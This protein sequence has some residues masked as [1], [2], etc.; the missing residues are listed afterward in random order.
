[1]TE[2]R[3]NLDRF[4]T[5]LKGIEEMVKGSR[6]AN[7]FVPEKLRGI[8]REVYEAVSAARRKTLEAMEDD[9]NTALALG[10]LHELAR[11]LNRALADKGFRKDPAAGD[12][13][14]E[15]RDCLLESGRVLG[16]FREAPGEYFAGQQKRFLAAKGLPEQEVLNLVVEREEARRSK[17]WKRADELR[18]KATA[19]GIVLEDG[20]QGTTWRPA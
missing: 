16:L 7:L 1:M 8:T 3:A 11:L 14:K 20:P 9:F 18:G 10:Y 13:L 17:D 6:E 15:G 12:L 5:A 2:A 4:Y 19:L